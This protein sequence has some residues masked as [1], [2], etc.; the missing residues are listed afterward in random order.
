MPNITK[1]TVDAAKPIGKKYFVWD[2]KLKGFGLQV[3]PS[4]I[5][6]FIVQYRTLEGRSRR[7]SLGKYGEL[8]PDQARGL[9]TDVLAKVRNGEDPT[10]NRKTIRAAPTVNDLLDMYIA[11]HVQVHNKP[12]TMRDI[13]RLV[14]QN[15][16]P[17]LGQ[18][19]LGSVMRPDISKLHRSMKATP[20][21]GNHVLAILSKA[22]NL[23]EV[24]GLRP[25]HSNPV[26]LIKRYKENERDRFL[27]DEELRRLG[28][29]LEL[30]K[31]EGLPW[32]IKAKPETAKHL[33]KDIEKRRTP[34]SPMTFFCLRL[35][36]YTGAR[37]SEIAT[38]EWKHVDFELGTIALPS[39]KGDGRKP[40]PVS[41]NVL[42]ILAEIP[43]IDTSPFVLPRISD[44]QRHTSVEVIESAWQRVRHH[45]GIPDVR[46]H[47]LRHTVGTF[48]AQAGSNAFLISHLLRHR[49][50]T[51]TNRYVNQDAHPIRMLS[52][53][54]GERIE[55]GLRGNDL[56]P[57]GQFDSQN[58]QS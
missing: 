7:M 19:K 46:I 38:L 22:F 43:R 51:I 44:P 4:G 5:K 12:R 36:L 18:M 10:A 24:W 3:M 11:E 57:L 26:R 27:S 31:N 14:T 29:T 55:A 52:E 1:R 32:I 54:V 28:Q 8:T 42:D 39:R 35:L 33:R 30:A 23:A 40:H 45:A 47:D 49:N 53:T 17:Q 9:G 15:I 21:Q 16:R 37:L 41:A 25:E 50:V 56:L 6:S 13:T 34:I 48:A 58:T 2:G 20:R